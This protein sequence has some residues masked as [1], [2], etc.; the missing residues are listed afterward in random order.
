MARN[1]T[2]GLINCQ[3]DIEALE[4]RRRRL[5][6]FIDEAGRGRQH[7]A[8]VFL[9]ASLRELREP[10]QVS[11]EHARDA[12]RGD[13]GRERVAGGW[14]GLGAEVGAALVAELGSRRDR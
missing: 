8:D 9:G 5:I 14:K 3:M 13:R 6:E 10:H 7:R 2:L 1:V 4:Q 11:E 12:P